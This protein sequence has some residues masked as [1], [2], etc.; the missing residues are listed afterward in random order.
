VVPAAARAKPPVLKAEAITSE[1][2]PLD[3]RR[4]QELDDELDM[5]PMVDITFLLLIFFMATASFAMQ[6]SLEFPSPDHQEAVAA[7]RTLEDF[8]EDD[9]YII[10]RIDSDDTIWI[11]DAEAPSQQDLL[12]RLRELRRAPRDAAARP[13]NSLL[14]TASGDAHHEVVIMVLDAGH[15]VNMENVRLAT[16]EDDAL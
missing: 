10:V 5:T 7:P 3:F 8:E 15:A 2:E 12:S 11:E 1:E 4:R 6:K 13:P 9:D 14:V 16:M